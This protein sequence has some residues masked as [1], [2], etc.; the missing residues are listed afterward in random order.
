MGYTLTWKDEEGI[1]TRFFKTRK[2]M[3]SYI[4][5]HKLKSEDFKIRAQKDPFTVSTADLMYA[6]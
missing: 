6:L 5:K 3:D 4:R 2:E 1:Y